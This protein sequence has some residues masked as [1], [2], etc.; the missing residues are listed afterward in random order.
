MIEVNRT[1]MWIFRSVPDFDTIHKVISE[2][3]NLYPWRQ[4]SF[5][6][7][8]TVTFRYVPLRRKINPINSLSTSKVVSSGR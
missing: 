8:H 5:C 6:V 7:S 3:I 2:K 1:W 4:F